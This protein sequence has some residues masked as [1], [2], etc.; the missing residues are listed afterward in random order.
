[1]RKP[2]IGVTPLVDEEKN[3]Y[4]M[5]PGYI[6]GIA[7][8]GGLGITLPL[9]ASPQDVRQMLALCD[10]LLL[11]GG[12][13]V[14]PALYGQEKLACCG[15][16]CKARDEMERLLFPMALERDMPVLGICRG[17]QLINALLGGTLYQDLPLQHPS[18]LEHHQRPPY[19]RPVHQVRILPGTPLQALTGAQALTVNSCHHQAIRDLAPGLTPMAVA[20]DGLVE[21][22]CLPTASFVWAVQWHPEFSFR[23][24]P[25]AA[26]LFARFVQ[27]CA[28]A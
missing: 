5:L 23:T 12:Q 6:E 18:P 4:W 19:D 16:A 21:A 14:D 13:D 2:L 10:G 26:A 3:S 7:A 22:V 28:K 11:T 8:A 1:M 27:A 24:D 15:A 17:L 9:T 25:A 20:P